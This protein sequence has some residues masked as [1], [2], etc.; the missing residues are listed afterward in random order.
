MEVKRKAEEEVRCKAVEQEQ[1][2][3]A[4]E[5]YIKKMEEEVCKGK[6]TKEE[7]KKQV[8]GNCLGADAC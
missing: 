5:A 3:I 2:R 8:G 1:L 6:E 7:A 4:Q